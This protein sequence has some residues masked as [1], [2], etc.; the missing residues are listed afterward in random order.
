MPGAGS[1]ELAFG[2]E[3]D[4]LGSVEDTD[5]TTGPDYY[6]FGR[7]PSV[8]G[9]TLD[10]GATRKRDARSTETQYSAEGNVRGSFS[11]D[12]DAHAA[13]FAKLLE[14]VFNGG[15]GSFDGATP[16]QSAR[17][18]TA[19]QNFAGE[20]TRTAVGAIPESLTLSWT[21]GEM[22]RYSLSAI[23]A[24]EKD[25]VAEPSDISEAADQGEVPF[26]A[27]E[28]SIDGTV[29][30]LLQSFELE[31]ANIAALRYGASRTAQ[32]ARIAGPEETLNMN[33]VF[34]NGDNLDAAYGGSSQ[35]SV[36]DSLS[37]VPA[38]IDLTTAGGTNLATLELSGLKPV[39]YAWEQ[40]VGTE[41]TTESIEWHVNGVTVA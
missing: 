1:A 36:A 30:G 28:L 39:N 16:A 18:Y 13:S 38:T 37:S 40:L 24:D 5:G 25:D 27:A 12:A 9:P 22:V 10:Q 7:D 29:Q 17:V 15:G 6:G 8:T 23:Y 41:D 33:A 20:E 14:W 35:S 34:G 31:I 19:S 32:D 4:Y 11:V 2:L 21:Q 26:H 3:T